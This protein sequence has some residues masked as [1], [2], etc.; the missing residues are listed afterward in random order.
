MRDRV[1]LQRMCG[2]VCER[3]NEEVEGYIRLFITCRF[4]R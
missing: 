4:E 1:L 3:V 2:I